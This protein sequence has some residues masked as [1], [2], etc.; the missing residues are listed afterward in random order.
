MSRSLRLAVI[1]AAVLIVAGLAFV[2]LRPSNAPSA[3]GPGPRG[4]NQS[5]LS[6]SVISPEW[7]EWP[8]QVE[9]TGALAPWQEAVISAEAGGLRITDVL[10]D[11]GA[12]VSKGQE[13]ARLSRDTPL[14]EVHKQEAEVA[15]ARASLAQ[16]QANARRAR[17][18]RGSGAL[19]QQQVTDYLIA[20]QTAQADLDSAEASLENAR[21]TLARTSIKAVDEG[22]IT[23]RSA[24][25]GAVV[26]AG[27]ELFRLLRQGRVEWQAEIDAAALPEV[28]P[29]Q[30]VTLTLPS[31]RVVNAR[32]RLIAPTLNRD[33]SR[34]LVYVP[35]PADSG[36]HAGGY[37]S[38]TIDLGSTPARTV[39][40][41]AVVLRDGRAY[42][43]TVG[44]DNRVSRHP[45][46]TGR[47]QENR[48]EILDGVSM[49]D[50]I[51][52]AGGAFLSDNAHVTVVPAPTP[53]PEA[54]S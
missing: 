45:V 44:P 1:A 42:A 7:R 23:D 19:S 14:A 35:L 37:A 18:V 28:A 52:A 27:T 39:P 17:A 40:Q 4:A 26:S 46:T 12:V 49:D 10:V 20:E 50:R 36:A 30:R 21:L 13:L 25:L 6:V 48:V 51:V 54:G 43:F 11:V 29:G 22:I 31:G 33:T 41:S 2:F 8:R 5:V 47:R 34:A 16:A 15:R 3:P 9:A 38:G 53:T 24:N 32:V